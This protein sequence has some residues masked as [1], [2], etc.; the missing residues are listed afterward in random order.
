MSG[1][2]NRIFDPGRERK[3]ELYRQ[4]KYLELKKLRN[5]RK[6]K[7]GMSKHFHVKPAVC[8]K[9]GRGMMKDMAEIQMKNKKKIIGWHGYAPICLACITGKKR[10]PLSVVKKKKGRIANDFKEII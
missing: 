7:I 9:C 2:T 10:R 6:K 3:K 1:E 4:L 5:V 8:A